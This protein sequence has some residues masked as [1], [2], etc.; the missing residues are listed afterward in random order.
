[1]S[2][3][4]TPKRGSSE[5]RRRRRGSSSAEDV[6]GDSDYEYRH[7]TAPSP[8]RRESRHRRYHLDSPA[9]DEERSRSGLK[10]SADRRSVSPLNRRMRETDR[11][12]EHAVKRRREEAHSSH[13]MDSL[14][15]GHGSRGRDRDKDYVREKEREGGRDRDRDIS[16]DRERDRL[17]DRD[18]DRDRDRE[19]DRDISSIRDRDRERD[20]DRDRDR[21]HDHRDHDVSTRDGER[22]GG[23]GLSPPARRHSPGRGRLS[24]EEERHSPS[25]GHRSGRRSHY[26]GGRY[27]DGP[28]RES[29]YRDVSPSGKRGPYS[30]RGGFYYGG[31]RREYDDDDRRRD[32]SR[33]M[34]SR[35]G[36][37]SGSVEGSSAV[38]NANEI[39]SSQPLT[40]EERKRK[41]VEDARRDD[42][43]VLVVNLSLKATEKDI[44]QFFTKHAGKVRDIQLIKDARSGKSKGIGYVEFHDAESVLKSLNLTG[45]CVLNQ[46][47]RVQASQAEKNRAAKAAKQ[48]QAE[49]AAQGPTKIY[50]GGLVDTLAG[51][52]N[53]E[54]RQ[55]FSPFGSILQIDIPKDPYTGRSRG[56]A[57][58]QFRSAQEAR[59]AM[60]A[61]HGFDIGG[62][63]IKVGFAGEEQRSTSTSSTVDGSSG[64]D[65]DKIADDH[66]D[67]LL[68]GGAM[69]RLQLSQKLQQKSS[70]QIPLL[71]SAAA[72]QLMTA[73]EIQATIQSVTKPVAPAASK[74]LSLSNMF[75]KQ[76]ILEEGI[77]MLDEVLDDVKN[78][79]NR[80][81]E[82][83][84]IWVDREALDGKILV[85]FKDIQ[86]ANSAFKGL[87]GRFFGGSAIAVTYLSEEQW[88]AATRN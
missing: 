16:R 50:V 2:D 64:V 7:R 19:S 21:E 76:E 34:S 6:A 45:Q 54:L 31:R 68:H 18:R 44:W 57:F 63:Q 23:A 14:D 1:M 62:K 72:A 29:G 84:D 60:T 78:E 51:I 77:D 49:L 43:T 28:Y 25:P 30:R 8:T 88:L 82:V 39:K 11:D 10:R 38:E 67:R 9:Q 74:I 47:I 40:E 46:P 56:Y 52:T 36:R 20:R 37:V 4:E 5:K 26:Y 58:V 69:T 55:L 15:R 48:Q 59:E 86:D 70:D 61:M 17:R 12:V 79:C 85:K 24:D 22:V 41:E 42:L 75:T 83:I 27:R 66:D 80:F 65:L 35:G 71:S 81:G 53:D 3:E 13:S 87:N 32:G 33:D 73:A